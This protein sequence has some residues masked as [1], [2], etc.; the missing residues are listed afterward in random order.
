MLVMISKKYKTSALRAA[1]DIFFLI[2]F[3]QDITALDPFGFPLLKTTD[4]MSLLV[5]SLL[6]FVYLKYSGGNYQLSTNHH[7]I[8]TS[9]IL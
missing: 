9:S 8:F 5:L 4:H 7:V 1:P 2:H 6:L 3:F